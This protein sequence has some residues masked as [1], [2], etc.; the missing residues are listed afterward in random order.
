MQKSATRPTFQEAIEV[1]ESLPPEDQAALMDIVSKRLVQYRRAA[2][3]ERVREARAACAAGEVWSGNAEDLIA[4]L[5]Q[6]E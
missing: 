6:D 2:L 3:V 4:M 1:V 5:D